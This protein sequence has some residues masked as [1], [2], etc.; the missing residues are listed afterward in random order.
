MLDYGGLQAVA[1]VVRTGSFEKAAQKLSVTPS[2]V[3]QRVKALEERLGTILIVR[4]QPCTATSEGELI[5]RHVEQVLM[6]EHDLS[7]AL[8][9]LP[10]NRD[11]EDRVTIPLAVNSDSLA[12]WFLSAA[13]AA[14]SSTG[15][16][17]DVI[18]DDQDHTTDILKA[19]RAIGA[20]TAQPEPVAGFKTF[21]L[22]AMTYLATAS[23]A[24][25]QKY[26]SKGLTRETL[27]KAPGIV[28]NRK[29]RLQDSWVRRVTG[30][31][32]AF[33]NHW[34]PSSHAFI[35]A[36]LLGLGWGMSPLYLLHH[37]LANGTLVD[38]APAHPIDV[39]LY[40]QI[41]SSA[42]TP[43]KALTE[44]IVSC[45]RSNMNRPT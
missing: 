25:R 5:C 22:G 3:S 45:A 4:G 36:C 31:Q 28:F 35:D 18:V 34:L 1:M 38:L 14:S 29:D 39:P 12:T 24:F 6:L 17:F 15:Y 21:S 11:S 32:V 19:G 33:P 41:K 7:A 27:Q 40:W 20:V 2:A 8:P 42:V 37:H 10:P 16:L 9:A 26:F 13:A 43:L 44:T 23:P 30:Q